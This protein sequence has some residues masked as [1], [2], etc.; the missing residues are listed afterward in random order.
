MSFT[1]KC[2]GWVWAQFKR[3]QLIALQIQLT[4]FDDV[5]AKI[6]LSHVFCLVFIPEWEILTNLRREICLLGD[7]VCDGSA[8]EN[9]CLFGIFW[10][11]SSSVLSYFP[12]NERLGSY[13]VFTEKTISTNSE[14]Y[15]SKLL[16]RIGVQHL[17]RAIW[18]KSTFFK[19][20]HGFFEVLN[21][22][23]KFAA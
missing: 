17:I 20:E 21:G 13:F 1:L 22:F 3:K 7:W 12:L 11:H 15:L 6:F 4:R 5:D 14:L 19:I 8:F 9:M 16:R 10:N 18:W 23:V 2:I